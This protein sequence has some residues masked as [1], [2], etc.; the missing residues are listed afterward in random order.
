MKLVATAFASLLLLPVLVLG[1]FAGSGISAT[2]QT[3]TVIGDAG[4]LIA[5]V[6]GNP[7]IG[8]TSAA[9]A[10][11]ESGRV[12]PRILAILLAAAEEHTLD[13]VGPIITGHSYYVK[14]T[15]RVSNHVFGRAVDVL[16]VDGAPVS[17]ENLAARALM[18]QILE[19]PP[20]LR[21][22]ELGGPFPFDDPNVRT[23]VQDH[24]DHIHAGDDH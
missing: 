23:F 6:L 7:R 24:L 4:D 12:D 1:A 8:L 11:V 13:V 16:S 22:D 2:Q 17:P 9:R 3:S 5:A 20:P 15:T 19:L 10:D 14:G 21:P 18:V